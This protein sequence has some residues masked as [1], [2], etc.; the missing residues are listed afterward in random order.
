MPSFAVSFT[1]FGF[2]IAIDCNSCWIWH[3]P[4]PHGHV[5]HH[6]DRHGVSAEQN[7]VGGVNEVAEHLH[8]LGA[9]VTVEVAKLVKAGLIRKR[10][11]N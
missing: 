10:P 2:L 9:F 5:L 7:G 8:L 3:L 6:F 1:T 11:N 4:A